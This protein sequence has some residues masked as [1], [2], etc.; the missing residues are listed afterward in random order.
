M[1][2]LPLAI[3]L[4]LLFSGFLYLQ[5]PS[6]I[7]F[8]S[9]TLEATPADW[10]LAYEEVGLSSSD[11]VRLHG[12]YLPREGSHRAL[13]F[14][15]GNAGNISHRGESLA[16]FHRL[17]LN[18]LIIDYRGYGQSE[19]RP[20][21]E[22]LYRDARAAWQYL[23]AQRGFQ[24]KDIVLFGRSLGGAVAARLA[25]E[26]QPAGLIL[27]SSFSSAREL[28]DALL[29]LLSR[30][31]PLRYDFNAAAALADVHCPV[32]VVHSPADE[33]IP[34]ALGEK[35]YQAANEPKRF[36]PLYGDHNAGFSLSQPGYEEGLA[37][38]LDQLVYP[39]RKGLQGAGS[40]G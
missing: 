28:A 13:L 36:L 37:G 21:E 12:W 31:T 22:G 25:T 16:I 19:G 30:L 18:V 17:G 34:Y 39:P 35:L 26:V 10:G 1:G 6:M 15:H 24:A 11:G 40:Q 23:V 32:L 29:P 14:F 9:R 7:F 33:I 8:P 5:Q 2:T 27:E 4:L 3:L 20:S 38:F